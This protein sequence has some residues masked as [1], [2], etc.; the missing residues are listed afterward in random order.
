[1]SKRGTR[2]FKPTVAQSAE[3]DS[4]RRGLE[5][6]RC[7][8]SG[9]KFLTLAD[10]V[11]QTEIPRLTAQKLL[12]TLVAHRFLRHLPELDRYEPDVSCFVVGHAL[13]ASLPVV[14][15]AR[16][17]M[18][19]LAKKFGV[20]V[21]LA[22]REGTEMMILEYCTGG[23]EPA[24]YSAGSMIPLA[25]SAAGRAW[26]W[27][28]R[29]A[30]QAE[31]MERLREDADDRSRRAIPG[32]YGAFQ[33]LAERGYC[34]SPGEWTHERQA[35]AAPLAFEGAGDVLALACVSAGPGSKEAFLRDTV[36]PALLETA[37]GIRREMSALETA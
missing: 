33:D 30:T 26:L 3:V 5:I 8:R 17:L 32:I 28:Q 16:A 22:L 20:D 23:G 24:E 6:L 29:P 37:A 25:A 36:A 1:M 11:D 13:H 14:R 15:A 10:I 35:I 7:F 2:E 19:G 12:H 34:F 21:F 27:A 4:L 18:T 9:K 31:F